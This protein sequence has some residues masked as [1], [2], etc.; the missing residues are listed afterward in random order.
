MSPDRLSQYTIANLQFKITPLIFEADLERQSQIFEEN[1]GHW[2]IQ[3]LVA[4]SVSHSRIHSYL[5]SIV[6]VLPA[7]LKSMNGGNLHTRKET[8]SK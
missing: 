2:A 6:C 8:D 1:D 4:A 7:L 3:S 5:Q